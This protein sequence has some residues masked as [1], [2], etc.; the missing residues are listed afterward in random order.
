[1]GN[2]VPN[3]DGMVPED[4][5]KWY[6]DHQPVTPTTAAHIFPGRPS[7][8]IEA[9]NRLAD[10][11]RHKCVAMAARAHGKIQLALRREALC[12]RLYQELPEYARW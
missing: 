1:M 3:F 2:H 12:D 4:L 9:T 6:Y 8:Y 5:A 11:A 10:Y 7:G